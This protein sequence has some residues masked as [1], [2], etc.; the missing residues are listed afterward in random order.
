MKVEF[1]GT[2]GN[3]ETRNRRQR[4]HSS[5]LVSYYQARVMV[6][7]GE[8]WRGE[9]WRVN[10]DAI[11]ITPAHPDHACGLKDG[12]DCPVYA[13]AEA[14]SNLS[15]AEIHLAVELSPRSPT[16]VE[17]IIIEAFPVEHSTVAPAVGY[18][19]TAGQ[20]TVFYVSD[21][22]WIH[23]REGALGGAK[24]Y[25][26]DGAT[27]TR[28][29]VRKPENELIGHTPVRTQLTWCQKEGV[30]KAIRHHPLR[31]RDRGGR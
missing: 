20:V 27:L 24:R 2:R 12:A 7:C 8:D 16:D 4:M 10:P 19:I 3:I 26:G 11:M 14:W 21:V 31:I 25:I 5:M 9:L 30:P 13:T 18:R 22:V 29:M 6:D 15:H 1:L 28:S 17:S 23:D